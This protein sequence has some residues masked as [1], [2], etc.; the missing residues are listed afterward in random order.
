MELNIRPCNKE[1]IFKKF[2]VRF[3]QNDICHTAVSFRPHESI[4]KVDRKFSGSRRAIIH[5]R[6]CLVNTE[7]GKLKL[8]IILDRF[9]AEVFIN[10]G[11][12]V[13]TITFYTDQSADGISF[14]ADGKAVIDVVKYN[15]KEE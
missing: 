4:V 8:R 1:E 9:S 13:M 2:A 14:Y 15:L 5:Q 12:Q 11:E 6:R 3:A 10:D 7:D